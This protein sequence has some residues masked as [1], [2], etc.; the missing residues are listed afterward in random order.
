MATNATSSYL[1]L[2]LYFVAALR[3]LA[4]FLGYA[5]PQRLTTNL[6]TRA[7]KEVTGLTGRAFGVWTLVTCVLCVI[8]A[9]NPD[10]AGPVFF[11]TLL[12]FV[13]AGAFFVV[14]LLV[15]GTV[16]V[17]SILSP[18]IVAGV[19]TVWMGYL[20]AQAHDVYTTPTR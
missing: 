15:F 4:V 3:L 12:S 8:T 5:M 13:I 6:F 16:T 9:G 10:P 20:A 1:S 17:R 19:S 18:S 2:W 14:E 11:A 7:P